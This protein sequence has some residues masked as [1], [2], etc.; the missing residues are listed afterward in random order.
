MRSLTNQPLLTSYEAEPVLGEVFVIN[1]E[2]AIPGAPSSCHHA[3]RYCR[4]L[5]SR[6][7]DLKFILGQLDD[8]PF[9]HQVTWT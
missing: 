9:I 2:V 8:F 3:P 7:Q 1:K 4:H 6:T 5:G